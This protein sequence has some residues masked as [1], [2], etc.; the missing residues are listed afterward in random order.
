MT[1]LGAHE[2]AHLLDNANESTAIEA[3]CNARNE[4]EER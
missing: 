2:E 3:E 4:W 1:E